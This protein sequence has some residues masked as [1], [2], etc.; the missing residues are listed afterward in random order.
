MTGIS[1]SK[2][3]LIIE[4]DGTRFC[5]SQRQ[6]KGVTVQSELELALQKLT[7]AAIRVNLS[8]RTDAGVSAL[9]QVASFRNA[10][11]VPLEKVVKGLNHYLPEDIAVQAVCRIPDDLDVRRHAVSREYRYRIWNS[12]MPSPVMERHAHLVSGALDEGLMDTAARMLIGTHD[13]VSFASRMAKF[14]K[15]T[16][17]SVH[18]AGVSREGKEILFRIVAGSF[19]PH[20]V[21]NTV[22]ALIRVGRGKMTLEE[23]GELLET[24]IPGTAGPAVPGRGLCLV[25]INYLRDLGDYNENL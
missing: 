21:R 2:L 10:S 14:E 22:G 1:K 16:V 11:T 23:F 18:E 4:Y 9:G 12:P 20:Q 19:L 13:L 3:A 25:R 24:K 5:G 6:G 8:S 17:R 7:G 15:T